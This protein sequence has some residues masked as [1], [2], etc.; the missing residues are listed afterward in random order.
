MTAIVHQPACFSL[1]EARFQA[2]LRVLRSA[3]LDEGQADALWDQAW[4]AV[5]QPYP[6]GQLRALQALMDTLHRPCA[7]GKGVAACLN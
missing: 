1:V 5:E 7:M 2:V 3:D 6:A 4:Q